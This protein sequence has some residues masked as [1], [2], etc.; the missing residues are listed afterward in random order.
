MQK[1]RIYDTLLDTKKI[2]V[3][4]NTY[5]KIRNY[6]NKEGKSL[7]YL[8]ITSKSERER[9]SIDLLVNLKDW[10]HKKCIVKSSSEN[11]HDYNLILENIKSKITAIKTFFRLADTQLTPSILKKELLEGMVRV[12]FNAFLKKSLEEHK[13]QIKPGTH[14]RYL[15]VYHKLY[16]YKTNIF[17]YAFKLNWTVSC[18]N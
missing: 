15:A 5:F 10:D 9:V 13:S 6:V 14:R 11:S 18:R 8:Y 12:D 2:F 17:L 4:M 1:G 3:S 16:E 7:I